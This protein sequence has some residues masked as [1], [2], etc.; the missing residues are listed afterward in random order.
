VQETQ[1]SGFPDAEQVEAALRRCWQPVARIDELKAGPRRA[2]L[3]GEALAVF[4]TTSGEPAVLADRCPHRGASLSLGGVHGDAIRCPYHGW[5]WQAGDGRCARI[6]SLS[7]QRQIPPEAWIAAYPARERWGLVWTALE[8]P[9]GDLPSVPWLEEDVWSLGHG[10][11]FELP[12]GFGLMIENFRDVAHFAFVHEGTMGAMPEVI[13]ALRPKREGTVVSMHRDMRTG[14]GADDVWQG[15]EDVTY[16][17]C[18]PNFVAALMHTTEGY[19]CLLHAARAISA[20]GSAHYWIEGMASGCRGASLEE[21][22]A[23]E[24]RIYA[25]DT[26]IISTVR[27]T[28]LS[29]DPV[30]EVSTLSDAYTLAYREAFREFVRDAN[31]AQSDSKVR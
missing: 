13:E 2:V 1:Q 11:P 3:L 26:A 22:I 18:A 8:E 17:V 27:P 14:P 21:A 29:L 12:V 28:E 25:E 20:V 19:R 7:D 4:M 24:E 15:M 30:T 23:S 6:P 10:R 5:E 31:G 9:R 16:R